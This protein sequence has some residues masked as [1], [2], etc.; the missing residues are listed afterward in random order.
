MA[1]ER[2]SL[3]QFEDFPATHRRHFQQTG[4]LQGAGVPIDEAPLVPHSLH[5]SRVAHDAAEQY[6]DP[7]NPLSS[8]AKDRAAADGPW[9]SSYQAACLGETQQKRRSGKRI[10]HQESAM[11][12]KGAFFGGGGLVIRAEPI[13]NLTVRS[14]KI[15]PGGCRTCRRGSLLRMPNATRRGSRDYLHVCARPYDC[16]SAQRRSR[17]TS[18]ATQVRTRGGGGGAF[19]GVGGQGT[20]G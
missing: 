3:A 15:G 13:S 18:P 9:V 20:L 16:S 7:Y 2:V 12:Q 5:R 4:S 6:E 17:P 19:V 8:T 1:T 14:V 10:V 11:A